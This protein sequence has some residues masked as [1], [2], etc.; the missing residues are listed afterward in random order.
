MTY[1][2]I[3]LFIGGECLSAVAIKKCGVDEWDFIPPESIEYFKSEGDPFCV[4]I[5]LPCLLINSNT[6]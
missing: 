2:V 1:L 6:I 4:E 3:I 5:C